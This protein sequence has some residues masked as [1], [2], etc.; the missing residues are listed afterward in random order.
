MQTAVALMYHDTF[1]DG[2]TGS[3]GRCGVGPDLYKVDVV[4]FFLVENTIITLLGIGIGLILAYAMNTAMVSAADNVSRLSVGLVLVGML[5]VWGVGLLATLVPALRAQQLHPGPPPHAR[6]RTSH[7][8][9]GASG[10]CGQ[11]R[12]GDRRGGME[13][14]RPHGLR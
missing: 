8:T 12:A 1:A 9:G 13:H 5:I 10:D 2:E 11:P 4:R 6:A 14:R 7:A 3:S